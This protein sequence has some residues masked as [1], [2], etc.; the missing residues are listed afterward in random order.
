MVLTYSDLTA[1]Q[2][3]NHNCLEP[4]KFFW[5]NF[6]KVLKTT[7]ASDFIFIYLIGRSPGPAA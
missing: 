1:S 5:N 4:K 7:F 3:N 2:S 6:V